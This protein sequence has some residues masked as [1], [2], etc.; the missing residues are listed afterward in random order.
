M[1]WRLGLGAILVLVVGVCYV[2]FLAGGGE[3]V[4]AKD[5]S[6]GGIAKKV[7][8]SRYVP[9]KAAP[10]RYTAMS[11]ELFVGKIADQEAFLKLTMDT[12]GNADVVYDFERLDADSTGAKMS[13]R[14]KDQLIELSNIR[15][16]DGSSIKFVG[17]FLDDDRIEGFWMTYPEE[18][19]I[20][21]AYFQREASARPPQKV[22]RPEWSGAWYRV[23]SPFSQG[24]LWVENLSS[25]DLLIYYNAWNGA[26][27]GWG[28]GLAKVEGNQAIWET[29]QDWQLIFTLEGGSLDLKQEAMREIPGPLGGMGVG[30]AGEYVREKPDKN[31]RNSLASSN[32]LTVGQERILQEIS[33]DYYNEFLRSAHLVFDEEDLDGTGAIV[34][35]MGVRGL[36]TY[37]ESIVM[38]NEQGEMW[39]ATIDGD[40]VR[41]FTNTN[42]KDKLPLTIEK[43]R[44]RFL[45]R[46]VIF[47]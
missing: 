44:E 24:Y 33:G 38:V 15:D 10:Q 43:W 11:N 2:I 20:Q 8:S 42:Q 30:V 25:G 18:R 32:V 13:G 19:V 39:A 35:R 16:I 5:F 45:Y 6:A 27:S 29:Q 37:V 36:F 12:R 9:K 40:V 17:V 14:R 26:N 47:E 41:Y 22:P 1:K 3:G 23:G 7:A 21:S 46:K 28:H 31:K 4:S 34:K